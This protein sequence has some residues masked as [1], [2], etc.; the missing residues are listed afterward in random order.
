MAKSKKRR[1]FMDEG[2][3][4]DI[5]RG[6]RKPMPPPSRV[7]NPKDAQKQ[8]HWD[9]RN[10]INGNDEVDELDGLDETNP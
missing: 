2:G 1:H 5:M 7:I 3:Q 8:R 4:L 6:I 10:E 9:W